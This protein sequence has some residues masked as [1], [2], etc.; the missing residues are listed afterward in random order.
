[1]RN[2][3]IIHVANIHLKYIRLT[4]RYIDHLEITANMQS[5]AGDFV[6]N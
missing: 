4:D 6:L 2:M 1:M 3:S 5:H